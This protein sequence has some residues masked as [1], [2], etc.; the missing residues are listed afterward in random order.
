M[1]PNLGQYVVGI[2]IREY[3]NGNLIGVSQR[4]FQLLVLACP[5][6]ESPQ[7]DESAQ[8]L[9]STVF[10]ITE[11]SELCVPITFNDPDQ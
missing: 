11:G 9:G 7:L 4:D 1:A 6:Q 2:E 8:G 3:R 10:E 5:S